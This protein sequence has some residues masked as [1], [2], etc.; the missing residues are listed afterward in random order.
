MAVAWLSV[1]LTDCM[2][3]SCWLL[4]SSHKDMEEARDEKEPPGPQ[5][6]S[7]VNP[8]PPTAHPGPPGYLPMALAGG[9]KQRGNPSPV[10]PGHGSSTLQQQLAD[11]QLSSPGSRSQR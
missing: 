9:A 8:T 3:L 5:V 2:C 11:L 7:T 6:V 4:R 10:G 1:R